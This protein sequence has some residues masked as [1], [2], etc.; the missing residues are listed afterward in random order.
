MEIHHLKGHMQDMYMA[1]YPDQLLL[2]D[3]GCRC[4]VPMIQQFITQ[5]LGRELHELK[6]VVVTHIHPDH[7][8]GA[9][10]LRKLTGCAIASANQSTHWYG[11]VRGFMMYL[12]DLYLAR[13]IIRR[14][15]QTPKNLFFNPYLKP[16]Y[17]LNNED[18][19]PGFPDWQVLTTEGHTDRDL[20][21]YHPETR[22]AY[23]ADL[24][25]KTR[26]GYISPFPVYLPENYRASLQKVQA[27]NLQQQYLAHGG[28][29]QLTSDEYDDF[30]NSQV[31]DKPRTIKHTF[32]YK[33]RHYINKQ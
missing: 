3:G 9:H 11:G 7:A 12:I 29:V 2:L 26:R 13:T 23:T 30:I 25:I 19:L 8:G 21:V 17:R 10:L 32:L 15:K 27:L 18:T 20:T 1:V 6:L 31:P 14:I 22:S 16:D 33:A 24:I 4:D 5:D 28:K